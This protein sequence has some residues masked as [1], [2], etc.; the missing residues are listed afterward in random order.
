MGLLVDG[1]PLSSEDL[2][3]KLKYIKDHGVLQFLNT[4]HRAKDYHND[5]LKFGDEIETGVFE[6]DHVAKTVKLYIKGAELMKTL[7][8]KEEI[9]S[10]ETEGATWHAEFGAWMIESTPSRPYSNYASDLL[11]VERNMLMRR[12]R[13]LSV[14]GP[15]SISPTVRNCQ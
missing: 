13:I 1:Q 15:D 4:W 9:Y 2:K 14:M 10:H 8:E 7:R 11:R 6:V 12:R 3:P 5:Q